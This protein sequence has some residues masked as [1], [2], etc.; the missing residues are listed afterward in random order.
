M[1]YMAYGKT[2]CGVDY[3]SLEGSETIRA[4]LLKKNKN[5]LDVSGA[6]ECDG[7]EG[8]SQRLPKGQHVHL[9]VNGQQVL[10]KIVDGNH[11]EAIKTV[12]RAFPNLDLDGFH[13]E[14]LQQK[15]SS[16]VSICRKEHI[17]GLL[18]RFKERKIWIKGFSL[19]IM[20]LAT[21]LRYLNDGGLALSNG[22][23]VI[24]ANGSITGIQASPGSSGSLKK[25]DVNGI[26]V[27]EEKLLSLAGA[28]R[29]FLGSGTLSNFGEVNGSL[30][31]AHKGHRFTSLSLKF[32][33][34]SILL[35]LLINFGFFNYYFEKTGQLAQL[36]QVNQESKASLLH[37]TETVDRKETMVEDLIK[38]GRSK[39][40]FYVNAIVSLMPESIRLNGI[41]YQP[42]LKRLKENEPVQVDGNRILVSGSSLDSNGFSKFIRALEALEWT[43]KVDIVDYGTESG[44]ISTFIIKISMIDV[45]Q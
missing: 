28:L 15:G 32:G 42:L 26:E 22:Q 35:L 4:T 10:T 19:G 27:P 3:C 5:T 14:V 43:D 17:E 1:T 30:D 18:D 9:S 12:H 6:F 40:S 24:L 13:Y 11:P 31:A 16:M 7:I 39:S 36:S 45:G 23:K 34:G 33:M 38:N 37:L 25:L 41:D 20:P 44:T 21:V 8:L 29:G 2:Y